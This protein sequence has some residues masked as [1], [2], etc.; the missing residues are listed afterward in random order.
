MKAI[1]AATIA[2]VSISVSA[3]CEP[4]DQQTSTAA[5]ES[6]EAQREFSEADR[7]QD[8]VLSRD[9]ATSIAELNFSSADTDGNQTL[10]INEYEVAAAATTP[11]G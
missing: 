11:R 10:S 4:Q 3:A 8:G 5:N 7:N 6:A 2:A 1:A 9:E